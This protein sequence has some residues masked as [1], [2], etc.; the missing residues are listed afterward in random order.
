MSSSVR[1][2]PPSR[3]P[4]CAS[5][6]RRC[7]PAT[8]TERRSPPRSP[9]RARLR[10]QRPRH[11]PPGPR[12]PPRPRRHLPTRVLRGLPRRRVPQRPRGLPRRR[13]LSGLP[14]RRCRPSSVRT[15][16]RRLPHAVR[17]A[18]RVG[19]SVPGHVRH[20][21]RLRPSRLLPRSPVRSAPAEAPPVPVVVP[22][23]APRAPGTTRSPRARGCRAR[24]G[25]TAP[26]RP[27]PGTT[28]SP[29]ARECPDPVVRVRKARVPPPRA[30]GATVPAV[31][32]P[33]VR[34]LVARARTRG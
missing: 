31:R 28:R 33:V 16:L 11:Q 17:V 6:A 12:L 25:P 18:A 19:R 9:R 30:R 22:V 8:V 29:P 14:P 34:A 32:V 20:R 21:A 10:S 5:C 2:H 13:L 4:S 15:V 26:A 7:R 23:R 27:A 3:P 1:R 24:A